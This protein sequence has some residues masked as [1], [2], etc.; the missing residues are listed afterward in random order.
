[1]GLDGFV[2]ASVPSIVMVPEIAT[3]TSLEGFFRGLLE[4]ALRTEQ[5][6]LTESAQAYLVDLVR[7]FGRSEALF[8]CAQRDEPGTPALVWM[9]Q[10][11][12][13]APPSARFE[14]YRRLGDV[15]LFVSGFFAPH[16]ER[17]RSLVG[18]DYYV[19]MGRTG[20]ASA[21]QFTRARG[22]SRLFGQL[23]DEF[24]RLVEVLTRV[25]EETTLPVRADLSGLYDRLLR[26]PH[27]PGL[28][29]RLV[30]ARGFP[31]LVGREVNA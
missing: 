12:R 22:V 10:T 1:M 24:A 29:R 14:A 25:A 11:A 26:N 9:Y 20:Y 2:V 31:V 6:E 8:A 15:A 13:E 28:T 19:K 5:V 21:G 16:I 30:A 27:S 18:V 3:H 7:S 17:Q 23:A 4:T